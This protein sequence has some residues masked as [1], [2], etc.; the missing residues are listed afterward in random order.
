MSDRV[1]FRAKKITRYRERH[2][3]MIK[4]SIHQKDSR[5]LT[6]YAP[7]DRT[8]KCVQHKQTELRGDTGNPQLQWEIS[9]PLSTTGRTT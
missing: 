9:T 5:I 6:V 3:V 1:N 4:G 2:Y 8:T 7:D